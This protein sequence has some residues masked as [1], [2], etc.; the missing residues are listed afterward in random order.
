MRKPSSVPTTIEM[1]K[2]TIVTQNV[3]QA[4][5]AIVPRNSQSCAAIRE[6]LGKM[7]SET[8]KP[9]Q[10]PSQSSSVAISSSQGAQRSLSRR[11]IARS[12]RWRS[13][14]AAS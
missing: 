10:M 8:A 9:R 13:A 11:V 1:P 4:W 6:G 5:P 2:P 7:N 14:S 12:P 3:R